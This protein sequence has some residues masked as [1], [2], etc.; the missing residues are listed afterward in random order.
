MTN[1]LD[2]NIKQTILDFGSDCLGVFGGKFEGGIHLQ[3]SIDEITLLI[4]FLLEE[5]KKYYN[6]LEIGSA[7]GG[8][9]FLL[10]YFLKFNSIY[11]VD[12]NCHPK[13]PLRKDILKNIEY[14]EYIGNSQ[15]PEAK[16]FIKEQNIEFDIIF[17]DADH[18]YHGVKKDIENFSEFLNP[19]GFLVF[20]DTQICPGVNQAINDLKNDNKFKFINEF[21]ST[22]GPKLGIGVFQKLF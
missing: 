13:Y 4:Q 17:I 8:N 20:H 9:T 21:I 3:Q 5:K 22:T 10:N 1:I 2:N 14:K 6:F 16:I 11:I 15:S 7:A 12:N 18:S 19:S